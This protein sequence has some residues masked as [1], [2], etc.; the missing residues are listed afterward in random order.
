M[1]LDFYRDTRFI[2]TSILGSLVVVYFMQSLTGAQA[3]ENLFDRLAHWSITVFSLYWIILLIVGSL[4]SVLVFAQPGVFQ[5][6]GDKPEFPALSWFAMILCSVTAYHAVVQGSSEPLAFFRSPPEDYFV[7]AGTMATSWWGMAQT[8]YHHGFFVWATAIG[9]VSVLMM[10]LHYT[11]KQPLVPR[12]LLFPLLGKR[13]THGIIGYTFDLLCVLA[14]LVVLV[15]AV[16]EYSS[17]FVQMIDITTTANALSGILQTVLILLIALIFSLSSMSGLSRGLRFTSE[18]NAMLFGIMIVLMLYTTSALEVTG[19]M[20]Y[21]L[22]FLASHIST[23]V[24]HRGEAMGLFDSSPWMH[25]WASSSWSWYVGLAPLMAC[26]IARISRG[27]STFDVLLTTAV[28]I[29]T[30]LMIWITSLGGKNA[31]RIEQM[32][33]MGDLYTQMKS[34]Q[35]L[36]DISYG[37]FGGNIGPFALLL[38]FLLGML[39]VST[40]GDTVCYMIARVLTPIEQ[41]TN[42]RIRLT[43]AGMVTLIILLASFGETQQ[44]ILTLDGLV[45]FLTIPI[46]LVLGLSF[47][48][49]LRYA[50]HQS[51]GHYQLVRE[52]FFDRLRLLREQELGTA[53]LPKSNQG[54]VTDT[55]D[56]PIRP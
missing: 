38:L 24:A 55:R 12:S 43:Y 17:F 36:I 26:F 51:L 34:P 22:T 5:R 53:A 9:L 25:Y 44:V 32:P 45:I 47:W 8:I 27:R 46:S 50:T 41:K 31:P 1:K 28:I 39:F 42:Y 4:V 29:P 16:I 52:R 35:A 14:G 21:S 11:H 56:T 49:V 23:I 37:I 3:M 18:I 2:T 15:R 19:H 33:V 6:F 48:W 10:H 20:V 54:T 13:L 40:T 7:A 30:L